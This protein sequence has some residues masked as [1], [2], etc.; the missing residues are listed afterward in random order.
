[1]REHYYDWDILYLKC[2]LCREFLPIDE[3]YKD[4][5]RKFW[6]EG[7]CKK[8]DDRKKRKWNK[9][10]KELVNAQA[11]RW[12]DKNPGKVKQ[13]K[14]NW[15]EKKKKEYWYNVRKFH[16]K[17]SYYLNKYNL[18][19]EICSICGGWWNIDSHH[20][21][22]NNE[23]DWKYIVFVCEKCHSDIHAWK[24]ECPSPINLLDLI[25]N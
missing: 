20:P 19:P 18:R 16:K 4:K 22:Y 12:R 21:S 6:V 17:V 13:Y 25:P 8:C 14:K 3:F 15:T 9:E 23:D 1:M 24:I 2:S 10:H 7:R 11:K 5:S